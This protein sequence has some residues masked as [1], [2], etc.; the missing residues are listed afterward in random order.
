MNTLPPGPWI[1]WP[2]EFSDSG[3]LRM[4]DGRPVV[5]ECVQFPTAIAKLLIR[6]EREADP[7][8]LDYD[9]MLGIGFTDRGINGVSILLPPVDPEAAIA[10][11]FLE[12]KDEGGFCATLCQ[13]VPDDP[14]VG[15]DLICLTSIPLMTTRG[16][17]RRLAA[18]FGVAL[19]ETT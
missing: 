2:N 19:K 13:G 3:D 8:P 1:F 15:D 7:T 16:E 11:L 17:L 4:K 10:E 18:V 6:A 9:W 5:P 14:H 12:E